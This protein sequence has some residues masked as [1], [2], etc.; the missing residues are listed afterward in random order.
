MLG[1]RVLELGMVARQQF[2]AEDGVAQPLLTLGERTGETIT[3][4]LVD[5]PWRIC[6]YVLEAP[7]DLRHVVQA[8]LRYPLYLGAAGKAILAYVPAEA[9]STLLATSPLTRAEVK[10]VTAQLDEIR[11]RGVAV[12]TGERV[13]GA[14][15]VAAPVFVAGAIYGSVAVVGPTER[16]T[17]VLA[18]YEPDVKAAADALSETLSPAYSSRPSGRPAN[19]A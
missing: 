17:P 4:S 12:T 2:S 18:E 5:L 8:G 6:V 14:T 1:A 16:I 10:S 11:E 9:V 19:A 15:T 13:P 7:S 3:F